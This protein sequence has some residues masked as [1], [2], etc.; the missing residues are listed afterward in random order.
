MTDPFVNVQGLFH[1][2]GG[3]GV[4]LIFSCQN[5]SKGRGGEERKALMLRFTDE[6]E[7]K[8]DS[9]RLTSLRTESLSTN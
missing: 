5:V 7:Q 8:A 1:G 3:V 2:V 6:P 4:I 9:C